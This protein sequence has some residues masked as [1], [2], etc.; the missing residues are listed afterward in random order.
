MAGLPS[1]LAA[2]MSLGSCAP[3]ASAAV[4]AFLPVTAFVG[5]HLP[6]HSLCHERPRPSMALAIWSATLCL[7]SLGLSACA[8]AR[9]P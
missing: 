8:I 5:V 9:A 1:L 2:S 6:A 7:E 4:E 3:I